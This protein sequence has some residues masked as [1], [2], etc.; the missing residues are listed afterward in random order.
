MFKPCCVKFQKSLMT[1]NLCDPDFYRVVDVES[2]EIDVEE[3]G[4]D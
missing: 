1:Y 3:E 2:E 4:N